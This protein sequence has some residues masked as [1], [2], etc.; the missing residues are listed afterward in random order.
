MRT[1]SLTQNLARDQQLEMNI[2]AK[3]PVSHWSPI[4]SLGHQKEGESTSLSDQ[5]LPSSSHCGCGSPMASHSHPRQKDPPLNSLPTY[6][7]LGSVF[8]LLDYNCLQRWISFCCTTKWISCITIAR[9]QKQGRWP[10][11][12]EWIKKMWYTYLMGSVI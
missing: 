9:S 1:Q 6:H 4:K 7:P 10:S 8:L 2:T 3:A 12:D 5:H 11:T